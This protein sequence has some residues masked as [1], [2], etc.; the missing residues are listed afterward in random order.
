[1]GHAGG[2]SEMDVAAV[3]SS[4]NSYRNR[5]RKHSSRGDRRGHLMVDPRERRER[6]KTELSDKR[7]QT[8]MTPFS[9][10][11]HFYDVT[12]SPEVASH[13]FSECLLLPVSAVVPFGG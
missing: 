6:K 11:N 4:L 12:I 9:I 13:Y 5:R 2:C 8:Y 10:W 3:L 7:T 1:M